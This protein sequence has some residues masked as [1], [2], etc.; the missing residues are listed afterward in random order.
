MENPKFRNV[1]KLS[2]KKTILSIALILLLT[3]SALMAA[4][5]MPVQAQAESA[6]GNATYAFITVEPNPVG[7]GQTV[8]VLFWIADPLPSATTGIGQF[9]TGYMLTINKPDGTTET[10]GPFKGDYLGSAGIAY[11]PT[12]VGTYTFK[13]DYP[14]ETIYLAW[15]NVNNQPLN[16]QN[17][18]LDLA[19]TA[20]TTLTVQAQSITT[21]F[22]VPY[23]TQFWTRP[24]YGQNYWWQTISG[25][26][27]MAA[28][29]QTGRSFDNNW[30]FVPEGTLA[31]S[32]HILWT[33]PMSFGGLA[34]GIFGNIPYYSGMSY[35]QYFAVSSLAGTG[36][37]IIIG[38]RLFYT[39]IM[40]GEPRAFG[41]M[42]VGT[43]AVD[44][45]TGET[46]FTIP[47]VTMTYGQVLN[48]VGP[49]QAGT[50][51]YLWNIAGTTGTLYDPWTGSQI[52]TIA[53]M[54][55]GFT[56]FG[57]NGEIIIYNLANNQTF[58]GWQLTKWN[59]TKA[60][61]SYQVTGTGT[62]SQDYSWRPFTKYNANMAPLDGA[63]G[64]QWQVA[65][66][67]VPGYSLGL[68]YGCFEGN[69]I[70]AFQML[71][72]RGYPTNVSSTVGINITAYD[73]T[74]GAISYTTSILPVPGMPNV[75]HG[76][77]AF[78][79]IWEFNGHLYTMNHYTMQWVVYDLKTGQV[80]WISEPAKNAWGYFSQADSMIEAYGLSIF[81]GFDGY[82]TAYNTATGAKVWEFYGGDTAYT[83][84]GHHTFYDGIT[85]V[86]GKI[87]LLPNEHGNGNEPL[88][89]NLTTFVLDAKTGNLVW[90]ILGYFE[91]VEVADGVMVSHNNY[92]NQI[93]AFGKGPSA[94][95]VT[96]PDV[97]VGVG[98]SMIIRGT[99]TDQ[100]TGALERAKT[101]GAASTPAISDADQ[102]AWMEYLYMQ[103]ELPMTA[104]GVPVKLQ[105]IDSAGNVVNIGTVNS[106]MSGMFKKTW[107][108][109]ASGEYTIVATFEG[110]NSFYGSYAES[111][112]TVQGSV[113]G[114]IG[115]VGIEVYIAIA[116]IIIAII[117]LLLV[118][119]RRK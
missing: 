84:Y 75:L 95:T 37:A 88:Y 80:M 19:S 63:R 16:P 18:Y 28:W 54:T 39:T 20:T 11:T 108:P 34:G 3:L 118:A 59:S 85:V 94:T 31:N 10:Q 90:S 6:A 70:L 15:D 91:Q 56:T 79:N 87:V 119:F 17:S 8:G 89:Q 72:T 9:R 30:A 99:V 71:P 24:I 58:G 98:S 46:L 13:F 23:P 55:T 104:S 32:A 42:N 61:E 12:M 73:M 2:R 109:S 112:V 50:F 86:D 62:L 49:N 93:Y 67:N 74:T 117:A 115:G 21:V 106:D 102:T 69:N 78:N 103:Q 77:A 111:A 14:G 41:N 48:F 1:S 33:K 7:V 97:A 53:N 36:P 76:I 52:I 38:G 29:N 35:E 81:T 40:A 4:V 82:V 60:I 110:S 43:A 83:P 66:L 68:N 26:W 113:A 5:T 57:K 45:K 100:S 96:A 22:Q 64:I 105:A 92:D 116:A 51:A 44:L 101:I 25:N 27:L 114:T 107:T 65:A 47:N